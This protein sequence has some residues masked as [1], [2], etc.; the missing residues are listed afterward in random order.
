MSQSTTGRHGT[1]AASYN[2][3]KPDDE[4]A[5]P[6]LHIVDLADGNSVGIAQAT[7]LLHADA[8]SVLHLRPFENIFVASGL[9]WICAA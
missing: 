2:L 1:Q 6:Y 3:C 5:L 9:A 8:E 7:C 4:N